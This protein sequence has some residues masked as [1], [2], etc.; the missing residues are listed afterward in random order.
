MP[1]I[2]FKSDG[3]IEQVAENLA[4]YSQWMPTLLRERML[5]L[6]KRAE[7]NMK[8]QI[9]EHRYTGALSES[10]T[11]EYDDGA[12]EVAIFGTEK[13]GGRWD[14]GL[15]LEMGTNP[16][17]NLPFEPIKRWAEFRGI[18]A[19]PVWYKIR[20]EGVTAHPFLDP[21]LQRTLPDIEDAVAGI[22]EDMGK[23]IFTI[24]GAVAT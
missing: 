4:R 10:I 3:V 8:D 20:M 9:E 15:L 17:P 11:S 2:E 7:Q 6:G 1:A 16:I 5:T 21:T 23:E 22:M 12:Q 18:P 14:A 13:R 19:F 24:T